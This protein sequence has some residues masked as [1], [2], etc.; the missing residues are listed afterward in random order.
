MFRGVPELPLEP[1]GAPRKLGLRAFLG[2]EALVTLRFVCITYK[3]DT[4]II[5]RLKTH[6]FVNL[7]KHILKPKDLTLTL[8]RPFLLSFEGLSTAFHSPFESL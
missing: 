4:C 1:F 5:Q 7:E 8:M 6:D 3:E 2:M